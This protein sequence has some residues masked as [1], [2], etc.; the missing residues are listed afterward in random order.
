MK[1]P[2]PQRL[3]QKLDSMYDTANVENNYKYWFSRLLN[4]TLTMFEWDNIPEDATFTGREIELLLQ[5]SG[6]AR[7]FQQ[8]GKYYC[9]HTDLYDFDV[10]YNPTRYVY[11]N[12]IIGSRD[13]LIDSPMG[14][15]IYNNTLQNKICNLPI[16]GSLRTF[17]CHYARQLAD[18][19]STINIHTV[20]GRDTDFPIAK[21]D[22]MKKS[23]MNF[24]NKR[25]MGATEVIYQNDEILDAFSNMPRSSKASA[26]TVKDLIDAEDRMLEKFYRSV[27][28]KFRQAKAAQI[29]VE[30]VESDE[31]LLLVFPDDM[32]K[33]R[34]DGIDKI[35]DKLGTNITVKL[36]PKFDRSEYNNGY[37]NN[38]QSDQF[39]RVSDSGMHLS[40]EVSK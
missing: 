29:N 23:L 9:I 6:H 25:R 39:N 28:V 2:S 24:F 37:N 4:L 1:T 14:D 10:N 34:K 20:N 40:S 21:N 19:T 16:D 3:S 38:N 32:L 15:I 31:Q 5:L 17:L 26:D 30:E 18:I 12:P 35:N 11:A 33:A 22:S 8:D 36:N 27:G 7:I 13:G